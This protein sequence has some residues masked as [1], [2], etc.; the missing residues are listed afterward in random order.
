MHTLAYALML[1][2]I[3]SGI[4]GVWMYVRTPQR[5]TETRS[6]QTREAMLDELDELNHQSIKLADTLSPEMH[7]VTVRSVESL[8]IGGGVMA[9]LFGPRALIQRDFQLVQRALRAGTNKLETAPRQTR[10][11]DSTI[12]FMAEEMVKASTR[13]DQEARRIQQLLDMLGRRTELVARINQDISLHARMQIWLYLHV[14]LTLALLAA[15]L[16]HVIS[17]FLYW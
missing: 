6:G 13:N 1:S 8:R 10:D 16:T 14:P 9:Q 7:R 3:V 5:I 2:V 4:Y 12:A 17:V 15:L 11:Q